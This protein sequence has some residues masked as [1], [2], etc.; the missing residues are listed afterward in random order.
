MRLKEISPSAVN[1]ENLALGVSIFLIAAVFAFSAVQEQYRVTETVETNYEVNSSRDVETV[2]FFNR[3]ID[4][5]LEDSANATFYLDLNRDGSAEEVL[6]KTADGRIHSTTKLV[7]FP[8]SVYR[9][10]LRYQDDA[11]EEG[12]AWLEV[13]RVQRL[14]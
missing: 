4:L 10:H 6:P 13:Y 7:D 5:L 3:S 12:D 2:E 14:G 8:D 11:E 1:P 9:F